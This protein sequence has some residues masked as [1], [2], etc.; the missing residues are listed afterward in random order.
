MKVLARALIGT[1]V[2]A[3]VLFA[4]WSPEAEEPSHTSD[5]IAV[6]WCFTYPY[7]TRS[8]VG[9]FA[10]VRRTYD[11]DKSGSQ[12]LRL[13]CGDSYTGS[14][15]GY[16]FKQIL[17]DEQLVWEEDVAGGSTELR[18]IRVDVSHIVRGR[19]SV[20]VTLRAIDLEEVSSFGVHVVWSAVEA[21]G[22][23]PAEESVWTAGSAGGWRVM[24]GPPEAIPATGLDS[25][26][27]KVDTLVAESRDEEA[28]PTARE[29]AESVEETFGPEDL[30]TA[31]ALSHLAR[32]LESAD[33]Y[34]EAEALYERAL[35]IQ[36][37]AL[38]PDHPGIVRA[39]TSLAV[40]L[41]YQGKHTEGEPLHRRAVA[42]VE[43]AFGP[44]HPKVA[45]PLARLAR[46]CYY[47]H[48]HT[49]A[50]PVYERLLGIRAGAPFRNQKGLESIAEEL[51]STYSF[52]HRRG[53]AVPP[54]IRGLISVRVT[55]GY[56]M[57]CIGVS[58]A[59]AVL[60]LLLFAFYPRSKQNLHYAVFA[61]TV[62]AT[63]YIGYRETVWPSWYRSLQS[64]GMVFVAVSGMRFLY[65]II[66]HEGAKA[67]LG[68][69][70]GPGC[71]GRGLPVR[72]L[73]YGD[74]RAIQ[75]PHQVSA[76]VVAGVRPGPVP[77]CRSI[78]SCGSAAGDLRRRME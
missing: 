66:L 64:V 21:V 40:L 74:G 4:C 59:L 70:L 69:L 30:R 32:L 3:A 55:S 44:N 51:A 29:W 53:E 48:K 12:L 6:Q 54:L 8:A 24:R 72:S 67:I 46:V 2:F 60:H 38:G 45:G 49:E 56:L 31:T 19:A 77:P 23:R 11:V 13:S 47:Q 75:S 5:P 14:T 43:K 50:A 7:L 78:P 61:V 71:C 1:F 76:L 39:L 63:F 58:L 25:L 27:A 68:V 20:V 10:E 26:R 17:I 57:L 15:I 41:G 34:R 73:A 33:R 35:A 42:I 22:L 37:A 28:L 62:A 36:E 52:L 18:P 16:H 65:S 9:D